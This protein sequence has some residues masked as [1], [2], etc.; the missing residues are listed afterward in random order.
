MPFCSWAAR[1]QFDDRCCCSPC[2]LLAGARRSAVEVFRVPRRF[3]V[4]VL[5]WYLSA[6]YRAP[7]DSQAHT[8]S[9]LSL[10][11]VSRTT[12]LA[13]VRC[14]PPLLSSL[15]L[16]NRNKVLGLQT[17]RSVTRSEPKRT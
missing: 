7:T 15:S 9:D 3:V 8:L 2:F 1:R 17:D 16:A 11:S 6:G 14:Q 5:G 12:L 4:D 10:G 13:V